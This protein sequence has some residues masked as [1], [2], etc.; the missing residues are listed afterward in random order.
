MNDDLEK[1]LAPPDASIR[2]V[3]AC[4]D[5]NTKGIA[6]IVDQ[7][8]RL[9]GT[10]TDGDVRR[11]ILTGVNLDASVSGLLDAKSDLRYRRPITADYD[12]STDELFKVMHQHRIRQLPILDSQQHVLDLVTIDDLL[13]ENGLPLQAVIMAG[14]FGT[15]LHPLTEDLPKPMLP[16]GDRP[17]LQRTIEHLR[18]AGIRKV[19]V[20]THYLQ[21]KITDYFGD[22]K[23]F[24]VELNYLFEDHPMGTAGALGLMDK[25]DEPLLVING[26]ILTQIDYRAMLDFHLQ[27]FADMTVAVRQYEFKVPYGVVETEGVRVTRILEKPVVKNFVNAGIYLLSPEVQKCIPDTAHY[28][29]PELIGY[30]ISQGNLVISFPVREYWIDIG[31][32]KEY[33]QA[34]TDV[35]TGK[36]D[37]YQ[38]ADTQ[39]QGAH[40]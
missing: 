35:D 40:P 39:M 34:Q 2:S 9:I 25:I 17:L 27:N 5:R 38:E 19:Q 14:G 26:D 10:I 6:L 11:A 23:A 15:R 20:S 32:F 30:L 13:P 33:R 12:A 29:M 1:Y 21:E 4:I 8:R 16:V 36:F 31:E 22:G 18:D 28:D 7:E 24:G 3:M 37:Q